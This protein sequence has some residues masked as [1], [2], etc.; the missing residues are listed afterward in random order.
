MIPMLDICTY[1]DEV[2]REKSEEVKKFDDALK[3]LVDAMY[4]TLDEADGVGLAG[5]QVGVPSRLFIV[6]IPSE[7]IKTAFINPQIVE[8]S[9]ET[10]PYEEGCLSI[11]GEYFNVIRPLEVTVQA[12]DV[13]GHPFTV[14]ATGL[15]ARVIQHE[16]DHL[17]GKLFTDRLSENDR[18]KV[19]DRYKIRSFRKRGKKK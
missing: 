5:C 13:K 8:T 10:G 7:G 9:Y 16:Y 11:P 12:Q 18:T 6:S 4:E 15:L 2:L 3:M 17:E 1:G 19:L 14:H